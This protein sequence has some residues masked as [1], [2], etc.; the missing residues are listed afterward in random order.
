VDWFYKFWV[1]PVAAITWFGGAMLLLLIY[2]P[3]GIVAFIA[4]WILFE[5]LLSYRSA[6]KARARNSQ[7]ATE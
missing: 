5:G 1:L 6:E 2:W 4:A 7:Q 3:L